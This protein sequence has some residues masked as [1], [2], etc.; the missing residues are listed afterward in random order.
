MRIYIGND[1]FRVYNE[2]NESQFEKIYKPKGW[3]KCEEEMQ[4]VGDVAIKELQT[5][6]E[7]KIYEQTKKKKG[8]KFNDNLIKE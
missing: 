6:T 4:P 5:E 8:K 3:R 7:I 2:V 1:I